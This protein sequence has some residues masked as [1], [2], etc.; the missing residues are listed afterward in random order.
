MRHAVYGKKLGRD[1]NARRALA[2]NLASSLLVEGHLITTVAKAKFVKVFA[3]K[4]I[5][6][7][8]TKDLHKRRAVAS[9]LTSEAFLR[10][11]TEIAPGFKDRAGGYTRITK[12][13]SPR[14][15]DNAPMARIEIL[16]WDKTKTIKLGR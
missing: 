3:E 5:T 6:N 9:R 13:G 2:S 8:R 7:A 1:I 10:L 11:I 4:L 14:L 16:E 15:G 12:L